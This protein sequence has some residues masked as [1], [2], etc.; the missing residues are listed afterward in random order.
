MCINWLQLL[1]LYEE[2]MRDVVSLV[3]Q[4]E[5]TDARVTDYLRGLKSISEVYAKV[6]SVRIYNNITEVVNFVVSSDRDIA[7]YKHL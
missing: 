6:C 5:V 1:K 7:L 4:A 2:E 3:E